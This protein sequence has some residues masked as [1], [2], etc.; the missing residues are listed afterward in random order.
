[1][2]I[3]GPDLLAIAE[4]AGVSKTTVSDALRGRGRVAEATRRK[5]LAVAQELSYR[6]NRV[7]R[8]LRTH[9]TAT[10]GVVVS[11]LS[12]SFVARVSD[13]LEEAA[14]EHGYSLLLACAQQ[15]PQRERLAVELFLEQGADGLIVMPCCSSRTNRDYY[16]GLLAQG[17]HLV[18]FDRSVPGV[19]ADGVYTDNR[20]GGYLVGRHLADLGRRRLAFV[21]TTR[22]D[23]TATSVRDRLRG[24]N[25][26]L[27]EAGASPAA[28]LGSGI[29]DHLAEEE[30]GYQAMRDSLRQGEEIDGVFAVNDNTAVG[31]LH[32]LQE[33][34]LRL[35]EQVSVIGFD[36]QEFARYCCPPLSTVRQ[37]M[38]EIGEAAV[39]L[40]FRR[41]QYE[42]KEDSPQR[43]L[44]EPRLVVRHS[45]GGSR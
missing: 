41:I 33:G 24:L 15:N 27:R 3:G 32:A 16:R 40:L 28:V 37:P 6:P 11:R 39:Q 8:S 1:M 25:A 5:V 4:A 22:P 14:R 36:D 19:P 29:S 13:S 9:R 21:T 44:L 45:C 31:V 38:Q 20:T 17:I 43:V 35:P 10:L 23:R 7:A 26:A 18:F 42:D 12:G 2:A 30:F 34:G